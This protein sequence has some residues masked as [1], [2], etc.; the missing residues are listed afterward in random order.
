MARRKNKQ[1][2]PWEWMIAILVGAVVTLMC[3]A[4]QVEPLTIVYRVSFAVGCVAMV[5][6]AA[7]LSMRQVAASNT[8]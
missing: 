2:N 1:N 6:K 8:K 7:T 4:R 5:G 3:V